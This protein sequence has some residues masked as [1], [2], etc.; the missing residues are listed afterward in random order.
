[1][2]GYVGRWTSKMSWY[3][4]THFSY[5]VAVFDCEIYHSVDIDMYLLQ[6][7]LFDLP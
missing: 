6:S 7:V 1:M 2:G 4:S 5:F 3:L